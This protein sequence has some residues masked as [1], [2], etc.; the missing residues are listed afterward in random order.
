MDITSQLEEKINNKTKPLG[1]LGI[2]EKLAL[3]I[4]TIQNSTEPKLIDPTIL[5]FAADHGI[6]EEGVSAFPKEV[7]HQMV[8]NFLHGGAAIN[9]F[10]QQNNI[11]L[12][13]IDAGVDHDF[14]SN[15][16]I[17][18]KVARGTK[19]MLHSAAMTKEEVKLSLEKGKMVID[20]HVSPQ[21]TI[22]GFGEMGIGNTSSAS[23]IISSLCKIDI[24]I[25]TGKGTGLTEDQLTLKI[26]TLKKAIEKH[27]DTTDV[28]DVLQKFGGLEIVQICGAMLQA[29]EK[30]MLIMVDG[31]IA[32][33]AFLAA[34]KIN[35]KI[36]DNAVFCHKS[37]EPG[38]IHLLNYF[39]ATPLLDLG[40]RL[41]EGT[42]GAVAYPIIKSA[43][44][45]LNKMASF[46]DANVSTGDA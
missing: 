20:D 25:C 15:D 14:D 26:N 33:S 16:L 11:A 9:V 6:T 39:K 22:I 45:F 29:Y 34:Y 24:E 41:G 31:F 27:P 46:A 28:M 13:I 44:E 43:V 10:A 1:S 19:N 37:A 35:P 2:L 36:I 3:Q 12:K 23:L 17:D 38:H 5:V 21:C 32:S 30:K 4:G 7:T 18:C 40:M 42:G 8:L